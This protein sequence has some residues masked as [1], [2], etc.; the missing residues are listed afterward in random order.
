MPR[1]AGLNSSCNFCT[2]PAIGLNQSRDSYQPITGF[3]YYKFN[4]K[5]EGSIIYI[6]FDF[7]PKKDTF[8]TNSKGISLI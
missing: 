4:Y 7:A 8:G 2:T 5:S 1:D 3:V 6:H